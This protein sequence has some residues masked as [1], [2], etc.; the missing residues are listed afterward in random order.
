VKDPL[1]LPSLRKF[2]YYCHTS[3]SLAQSSVIVV[4]VWVFYCVPKLQLHN[5]AVAALGE[6][7]CVTVSKYYSYICDVT[8]CHMK[9]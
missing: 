5:M 7:V 6:E 9:V 1:N 4:F 2:R 3:D 8:L